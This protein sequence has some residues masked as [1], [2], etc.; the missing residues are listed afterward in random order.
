[1]S[2]SLSN[3]GFVRRTVMKMNG[4]PWNF[5]LELAFRLAPWC[6]RKSLYLELGRQEKGRTGATVPAEATTET[7]RL[8]KLR[9]TLVTSIFQEPRADGTTW[10]SICADEAGEGTTCAG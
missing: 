4:D 5:F 9:A 3:Q 8:L 10:A 6:N 1:M 2:K 7:G